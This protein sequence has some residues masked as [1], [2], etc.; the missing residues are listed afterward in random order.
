MF[1]QMNNKKK[2]GTNLTN[3]L[4]YDKIVNANNNSL[5]CYNIHIALKCIITHM[6]HSWFRRG[7]ENYISM[8]GD[9]ENLFK[10]T[11]KQ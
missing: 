6:G 2:T 5:R 10:K 11:P 1:K 8:Q 7:Y 4:K 3:L 9:G